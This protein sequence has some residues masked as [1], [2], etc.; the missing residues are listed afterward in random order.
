M[1][2]Q[3][4]PRVS[5]KIYEEEGKDLFSREKGEYTAE[6]L[7]RLDIE[8]PLAAI[9]IRMNANLVSISEGSSP[10]DVLKILDL[11][12]RMYIMLER[13]IDRPLP[14]LKERYLRDGLIEALEADVTFKMLERIKDNNPQIL[15]LFSEYTF[16]HR[17][18]SPQNEEI[19]EQI[20]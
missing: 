1:E 14:E 9:Q 8:N 7:E 16:G 15:R 18:S 4:L 17:N 11:Q 13:S 20:L 2:K 3:L 5:E 19:E 10:V 6:L 12:A